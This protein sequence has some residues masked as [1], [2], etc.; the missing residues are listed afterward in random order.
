MLDPVSFFWGGAITENIGMF[1]QVTY[2]PPPPGG[3]TDAFGHTWTWDNVDVRYANTTSIHGIHVIYG[4]TANNNPSVQDPWNTTP[5]WGFPYAASTIAPTPAAGT[6]I[7]GAFAAH[8]GGV[9]AYA[10]LT[11]SSISKRRRTA[12]SASGR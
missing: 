5:A 10:L 9:G 4:I 7:D 11:T 8:V 12:R 6:L 2:A 1:A 3:F